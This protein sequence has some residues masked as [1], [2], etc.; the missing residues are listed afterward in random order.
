MF[1]LSAKFREILISLLPEDDR[2]ALQV[3]HNML[4]NHLAYRQS[5]CSECDHVKH[6]GKCGEE[7]EYDILSDDDI[8]QCSKSCT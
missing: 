1:D 5:L 8:C 7:L 4:K 2:F 3:G 6:A